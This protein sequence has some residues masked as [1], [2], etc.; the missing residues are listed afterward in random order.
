M[1]STFV[2]QDEESRSTA[3]SG[4]GT[5]TLAGMLGVRSGGG[6]RRTRASSPSLS[7]RQEG[8]IKLVFLVATLGI[9]LAVLGV[10]TEFWVEL[11]SSKNFYNNETC[12][13]AHYGLWKNCMKKL[14]VADV[15][16][17]RETCGPIDLPGESNCT[18]FKIYTTGEN[19]IL[20]HKM[21]AK[22]LTVISAMLAIFSLFLMV[23]GAVCIVMALSKGVQF[24]LKPASVCFLLSG[25][26]V[27][28]SLIIFHQ[29]VL[30]FLASDH[31]IPLHH[32]LSWS[33]A[34]MGCAAILLIV[35]GVLFLLLALPYSSWEKCLSH[36]N[37]GSL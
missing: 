9:T 35:A 6:K 7:D 21:P 12:L 25:L 13:A 18:Y 11:A 22:N 10:G 24:F 16:H 26:L 8:K 27:F 28:L 33:V 14:W 20:F 32:E 36:R 4:R 34:C 1:W 19:T 15:D 30:S 2:V 31:S 17:E 23:M 37:D 5:E 29:S 3:V